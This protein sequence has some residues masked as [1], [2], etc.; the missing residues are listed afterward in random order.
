MLGN[1]MGQTRLMVLRVLVDKPQRSRTSNVGSN[2]MV[3]A[4]PG[5]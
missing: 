5:A 3:N 1:C 4:H 2:E